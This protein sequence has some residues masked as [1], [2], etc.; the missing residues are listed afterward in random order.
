[1]AAT[2][3]SYE[4]KSS[5]FSIPMHSS[6]MSSAIIVTDWNLKSRIATK[7]VYVLVQS[8]LMNGVTSQ[9]RATAWAIEQ[10]HRSI[11]EDKISVFDRIVVC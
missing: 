5:S 8:S 11:H 7:T 9:Y 6:R 1:M 2:N 3:P 10:A 4:S